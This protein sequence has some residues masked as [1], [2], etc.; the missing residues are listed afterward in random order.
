MLWTERDEVGFTVDEA[1]GLPVLYARGHDDVDVRLVLDVSLAEAL[2]RQAALAASLARA[3]GCRS[4]DEAETWGDVHRV[5]KVGAS[6]GDAATGGPPS[7][8]G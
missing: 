7:P 5:A 2:G 3:H 8:G 4:I 1:T 6:R